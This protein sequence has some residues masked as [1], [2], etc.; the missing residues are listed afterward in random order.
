MKT[1]YNNR[2]VIHNS[3]DKLKD[4][5]PQDYGQYAISVIFE[6]VTLHDKQL[7]VNLYW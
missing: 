7:N 6:L 4:I 5:V 3:Y 1:Y 2:N